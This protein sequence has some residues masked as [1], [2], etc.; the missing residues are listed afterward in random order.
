MAS[1]GGGEGATASIVQL[2]PTNTP[3]PALAEAAQ[4]VEPIPPTPALAIAPTGTSTPRPTL[5]SVASLAEVTSQWMPAGDMGGSRRDH[6]AILL[7]DGTVLIV[8]GTSSTGEIYDPAT[9]AFTFLGNVLNQHR[10]GHAAVVLP[11]RRVLIVGGSQ[12]TTPGFGICLEI[13]PESGG[14]RVSVYTWSQQA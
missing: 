6:A 7:D 9:R 3:V 4:T 12:T 5:S 8:G 14:S 1:G 13:W 10:S 11:D 2:N